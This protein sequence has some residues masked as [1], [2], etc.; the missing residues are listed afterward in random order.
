MIKSS[1]SFVTCVLCEGALPSTKNEFV[2]AHFQEQHRSYFNIDFLFQSSFLHEDEIIITLDFME[3]LTPS[4]NN[5]EET[6]TNETIYKNDQHFETVEVL[7][8]DQNNITSSNETIFQ[9]DQELDMVE[10]DIPSYEE[11]NSKNESL[12]NWV[13]PSTK[14]EKEPSADKSIFL[15][16]HQKIAKVSSNTQSY[17]KNETLIDGLSIKLYDPIEDLDMFSSKSVEKEKIYLSPFPIAKFDNVDTSVSENVYHVCHICN[18][19]YP[20]K[21]KL[22]QHLCEMHDN[23]HKTCHI[24][25]KEFIGNKKLKNHLRTHRKHTCKSCGKQIPEDHLKRHANSCTLLACTSCELKTFCKRTFKSH[26]CERNIDRKLNNRIK[27]DNEYRCDLCEYET[28]KKANFNRHEKIVHYSTKHKCTY[29]KKKFNSSTVLNKHV[30]TVHM[31]KDEI[32]LGPT[33]IYNCD[34]CDYQSVSKFS[35]KRHQITHS[36][37][38]TEKHMRHKKLSCQICDKKFN[39]NAR[40][41]RHLQTCKYK[42]RIFVSM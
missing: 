26:K 17:S 38:K 37:P 21:K 28:K 12:I 13:Y 5:D 22:T 23:R 7:S 14:S 40:L 2:E 1:R 4:T 3:S 36:K 25:N 29:C 42:D 6:S 10:F 39:R 18:K 31:E 35:V 24:C 15:N 33:T 19:T 9:N 30:S 20:S 11:N 27:K 8:N 34:K 32:K 16:D 41:T